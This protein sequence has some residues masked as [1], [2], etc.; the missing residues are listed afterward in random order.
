MLPNIDRPVMLLHSNA[1]TEGQ[2]ENFHC[3]ISSAVAFLQVLPQ[4]HERA[5]VGGASYK[6]AKEGSGHSSK[7]VVY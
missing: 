3:G 5:P 2:T 7:C 1:N 6:F 4:S